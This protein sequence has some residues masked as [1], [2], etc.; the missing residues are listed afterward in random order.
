V[1]YFSSRPAVRRPSFR[2]SRRFQLGGGLIVAAFIPWVVRFAISPQAADVHLVYNT[3]IANAFA[4]VI[5]FYIFRSITVYPGIRQS[6]FIFPTYSAAFTVMLA[7]FVLGRVDYNRFVLLGGFTA[8][9]LWF[10][11]VFF[12]VQRDRSL[13]IGIVPFGHVDTLLEIDRLD[14]VELK[15]P[16]LGTGV[17]DALVADF[18]AELPDEWER[19]LA[20]CALA[21]LPVLHVKQLR[22]SLTGRVE[23][24]HLSENSFGSLVPA[25]IYIKLKKVGDA[26]AALIV[27]AILLPFLVLTGLAIRIDTHGPALFKQRRVGYGGRVFN[28]FKFRT[29]HHYAASPGKD[30]RS[31]AITNEADPRVTRLGRILRR[32]RIDELPQL[33]NILRGDMSWIGPRPEAEI[34][35]KWYESELPFYRYRHI[36]RPGITGWA[37]VNQ[38]H[39]AEVSDVLWKLQY[40]FYYIKNFSPWLDLLIVF[41]TCR[42]LMTGFGSR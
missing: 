2:N 31:S 15:R 41:R 34:L 17:Y 30:E 38:G 40:D 7:F 36:V 16:K 12:L 27:G 42:T 3:V 19:F 20:D 29:M 26:A 39:V 35:S 18:R 14:W 8:C 37:Q 23:I 6:Y 32:L 22:E 10:Y 1:L 28:V 11:A 21:G 24:D 4:V 9:I 13:R 33:I 5:G 25:L